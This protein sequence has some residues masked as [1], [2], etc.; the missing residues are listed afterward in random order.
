MVVGFVGV[1][2]IVAFVRVEFVVVHVVVG[3]G[4]WTKSAYLSKIKSLQLRLLGSSFG[5]QAQG[6]ACA[7]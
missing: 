5:Q 3:D 4:V 6:V 1:E 2:S 7:R